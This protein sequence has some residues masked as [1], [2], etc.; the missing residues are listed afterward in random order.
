MIELT[1]LG[2]PVFSRITYIYGLVDPFSKD[3]RYVGKTDNPKHRHRVHLKCVNDTHKDRWIKALLKNGD[4]PS[5]MILEIVKFDEWQEKERYW[6]SLL[7]NK[8]CL[9]TNSSQGGQGTLSPSDETR[10]KMRDKKIGKKLSYEHKIKVSLSLSGRKKPTRTREH[11]EK[12][13]MARLGKVTKEDTKEILKRASMLAKSRSNCGYK[14]VYFD[15]SR[16][17]FQANIKIKKKKICLGR[18][19]SAIEAAQAYNIAA[20]INGWPDE[21]LNAV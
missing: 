13:R 10:L 20:K 4:Y 9:L 12:L 6:I 18:F 1:I 15:S 11:I 2:E 8:G 3:I 16:N 7:N 17:N 19:K 21:G 14:G 5:M